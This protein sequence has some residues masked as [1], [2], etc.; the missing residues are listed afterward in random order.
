MLNNTQ[1]LD[2]FIK[3]AVQLKTITDTEIVEQMA[4][5]PGADFDEICNTLTKAGVQIIPGG[6]VSP[7]EGLE[8]V[9]TPESDWDGGSMDSLH[10]YLHEIGQYPLLTQKE[11]RELSDIMIA[12]RKAEE[13]L[14]VRKKLS[15]EQK[16]KLDAQVKAGKRQSRSWSNAISVLLFI[17]PVL[18]REANCICLT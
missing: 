2:S 7:D 4:S 15:D 16:A 6:E 1:V 8:G 12:G 17:W 3:M 11:E 13:A 10:M 5:V 18:S 9:D 14:S